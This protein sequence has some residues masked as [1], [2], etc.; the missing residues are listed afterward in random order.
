MASLPSN[1]ALEVCLVCAEELDPNDADSQLFWKGCNHV[2]H[3]A[4]IVE[5]KKQ[6][7]EGC[8]RCM[9]LDEAKIWY[10]GTAIEAE[11]TGRLAGPTQVDA[12]EDD[13][14]EEE[15]ESACSEGEDSD[16]VAV[17]EPETQPW[18][19][20]DVEAACKQDFGSP[21]QD[22]GVPKQD[23]DARVLEVVED[24]QI[25]TPSP[26]LS[27]RAA[28]PAK[29]SKNASKRRG[30]ALATGPPPDLD[31][32]PLAAALPPASSKKR[33]GGALATGPP[34]DL[35]D[36]PEA[37]AL[38]PASSKTRRGGALATGPPPEDQ[39]Q[40]A[41]LPPSSSEAL[42]ERLPE[43]PPDSSAALVQAPEPEASLVEHRQVRCWLCTRLYNVA[44]EE[45]K[46][47]GQKHK[48]K[49]CCKVD[50]VSP[51]FLSSLFY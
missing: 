31:D 29:P 47:S 33:R 10:P 15:E 27:D 12:D 18:S 41:A 7:V 39:P 23:L 22:F 44:S 3:R 37:A 21:K 50:T 14:E 42:V 32:Q 1:A 28:E 16:V 49:T 36:Q 9:E 4:C 2:Y 19:T 11:A 46:N 48:C 8:P 17:E 35:E 24:A 30:G 13:G 26:T 51:L 38:P 20:E 25:R 34:P 5:A 6:G 40:A 45:L 43:R